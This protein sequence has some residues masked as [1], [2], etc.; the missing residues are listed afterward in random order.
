MAKVKKAQVGMTMKQLKRKYP[1]VDTTASGDVR[2]SEFNAYAPAK[3]VKKYS[4]T[5]D[6]FQRKFGNK[7]ATDDEKPKKKPM[8]KQKGG[9]VTKKKMQA[10]GVAGK[11]P[12]AGMVDPKGA[13]TKV[14]QRTLG[15]IKKG[16]KVMRKSMKS[17]VKTSKKK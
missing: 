3:E 14:Q 7:F 1:D 6:A 17:G 16:G 9:G 12:K 11:Q 10:G 4:D 8:K 2:G 5:Y 15:N 13:Y